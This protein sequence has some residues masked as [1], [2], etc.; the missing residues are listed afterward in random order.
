[1]PV[2]MLAVMKAGGASVALDMS[3]PKT[4][5]RAIL[6]KVQPELILT[7]PAYPNMLSHLSTL[8][9][10]VVSQGLFDS[11]GIHTPPQQLNTAVRPSD[12]LYVVFT[13]GST[14]TPKGVKV[15]HSNFA[16]ALRH[17]QPMYPEA[18]R[19]YDFSSHSFDLLWLNFGSTLST[20]GCLCIP[21]EDERKDDIV[22]SIRRFAATAAL[23]TPTLARTFEPSSVPLLRTVI[24]G[25]EALEKKD[26]DAWSS[27]VDL[28]NAYGPSEC[29]PATT[30][31]SLGRNPEL[32]GAIGPALGM[33]AWIVDSE[34][35]NLQPLGEV[36]E[37][38]LEGPCVGDGYLDDL[39]KT[40]AAF[41]TNPPW[42]QSGSPSTPGRLGRLYR[43]GDMVRYGKDGILFYAGRKDAQVKVRGQRVEL[44]EVEHHVRAVLLG[45]KFPANIV[46]EVLTPTNTK[47]P[48]LI[49]FVAPTVRTTSSIQAH[50]KH[51]NEQLSAL[52]PSYMIPSDYIAVEEI[53][54]LPSGKADRPRLR[55]LG[56]TLATQTLA[57]HE[58]GTDPE[59]PAEKRLQVMWASVLALESSTIKIEDNFLRIGGD[60][61]QAMTLVTHAR[62]QGFTLKVADIF[63]HPSLG[64]QA[65]LLKA[66]TD[67]QGSE[68]VPPFSLLSANQD[69]DEDEMC[70]KVALMTK[71]APA[72]IQD[73]FPCTPLQ[74]GMLA[75][76][77]KRSGDYV[78]KAKYCLSP[79]IDENNFKKAC[80]TL[81]KVTPILRTRIVDLPS[82]GLVQVV[83]DEP[84]QWNDSD[85]A[86][87]SIS[88]GTPLSSFCLVKDGKDNGKTFVWNMHHAIFDGWSIPLML[89]TLEAAYQGREIP[90]ST[91]FQKFVEQIMPRNKSAADAFWRSQLGESVPA[92]FPQL[93]TPTHQPKGNNTL[94]HSINHLSWP[95]SGITPATCLRTAWA[96]LQSCH[97]GSNDIV[98]GATVT[99][100][101]AA[102]P[103]VEEIVGPT[104]ATVPVRAQLDWDQNILQVQDALQK[105]AIDMIPFE[106]IGLQHIR[107]VSDTA[108]EACQ[109]QT[110]LVV[111][112]ESNDTVQSQ[113]FQCNNMGN[114]L[115]NISKTYAL[116]LEFHLKKH[117]VN[118][119]INYDS[120][121]M[122]KNHA[123]RLTGQL[124]HILRQ[125]CSPSAA[126]TRLRD[127]EVTT[128][129]DLTDIWKWNGSLE[130][131]E[132]T[133]VHDLF[134]DVV[135]MNP[136]APAVHAWDGKLTYHQLNE[137]ST[138]LSRQL[139]AIGVGPQTVVPLGFEKSMWTPVSI[140]AVMKA[141]GASL[142][143][144]MTQ[145]EG[146]LL[147]IVEQV[148]PRVVL[149]SRTNS[150]LMQRLSSKV[151]VLVVDQKSLDLRSQDQMY[152]PQS[153]GSGGRAPVTPDDLLYVVFTS[154]STGTPKGVMITH[155]N[156]ASGIKHQRLAMGITAQS[157]TFDFS[158]YLFDISWTTHL[159]TLSAGGCLCIPSEYDRQNRLRESIEEYEATVLNVTPSV[160][161]SLHIDTVPSL[162]RLILSG[163]KVTSNHI[164]SLN[165]ECTTVVTYGTAECTVKATFVEAN[166]DKTPLRT[167]G[168]GRGVN[169]WLVGPNDHSKLAPVGAVGEICIEGPLVGKGYF[170]DPEKTAESFI[171]N[172]TWLSKGALKTS[173]YYPGRRGIVY[174]TGDLA[175]YSEDGLLVY[176]GRKDAQIKIRGQRV[177]LGEVE[178]HV[179]KALPE[180]SSEVVAEVLTPKGSTNSMLVAFIRPALAASDTESE[181]QA[182]AVSMAQGL[183]AKLA[184]VLPPYMI[185]SAYIPMREIP[186]GTTGKLDRR[187][188]RDIG[189]A[190]SIDQINGFAPSQN[191][192]SRR[193]PK[194]GIEE[195]LQ[196][197]WAKILGIDASSIGADDNFFRLG[198]DSIAAMKLVRAAQD[199]GPSKQ[200][201]DQSPIK[202]QDPKSF[203]LF[204][205][206]HTPEEILRI[207][208]PSL[209]ISIDGVQDMYPLP[210]TQSHLVRLATQNPPQGCAFFYI[211]LPSGISQET[212]KKTIASIWKHF[213]IL[214]STH[215]QHEGTTWQIVRKNI[216]APLE[217][218]EI[219]GEE[220]L[221]LFSERKLR[222]DLQRPMKLGEIYSKF[223]IFHGT[224]RPT[225]LAL[226]MSHVQY[227]GLSLQTIAEYI[228]HSINGRRLP[229]MGRY[230]GFVK[231]CM[232]NEE[233]THLYYKSLLQGSK[234]L[235]PMTSAQSTRSEYEKARSMVLYKT[236]SISEPRNID[237]ITPATVFVAASAYV[238]AKQRKTNDVIVS[239]MVSGRSAMPTRMHGLFG[240]LINL[241]P[242][243]VQIKQGETL[244]EILPAVQS[245]RLNSINY[246]AC[247]MS[248]TLKTCVDWP[249]AQRKH[250][251][252][253]QWH[254]LE[255]M[256]TLEGNGTG[257]HL[258]GFGGEDDWKHSDDIFI[259]VEPV[260]G[261]WNV[262]VAGLSKFCTESQLDEVVEGMAGVLQSLR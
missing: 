57:N 61:I 45:H 224:G 140:L 72:Q 35:Q 133:L 222:E 54:L 111:Q 179:H 42:L 193:K 37:L 211:D 118:V 10:M 182:A 185:P 203:S 249:Q 254:T 227:D 152:Q 20:G 229:K 197:L 94:V 29:T 259:R 63:Q 50:T 18:A 232:K 53:P 217:E 117:G 73:V 215:V 36:G 198:G 195:Q 253:L 4:R 156:F 58:R 181:M 19:V 100:R 125:V 123:Q 43:T 242:C 40:A 34:G 33:N 183:D 157:R 28:K 154:G 127:I 101:Q 159:H 82:E 21:S 205:A 112:P 173:P 9:T 99:G 199:V 233:A 114:G 131:P 176:M 202:G 30:C 44:G 3:L 147:S 38:W 121:T 252:T 90:S 216:T 92:V 144:D 245:Q 52:L 46:A 262:Y 128:G 162:K 238:L 120:S 177:E 48:R 241:V 220:N 246:E 104:I 51:V 126:A 184:S 163:E 96:I 14:G 55:E 129:Q 122:G 105:Q 168:K 69:R 32:V 257:P 79:D 210:N 74:E 12:L 8:P 251:V 187:K 110:L 204:S 243:R 15:S 75:M 145:P 77:A 143:L 189:N 130:V 97:T 49:V 200:L 24:L 228:G 149:T 115:D 235:V 219:C 67:G 85:E 148:K 218:Y 261:I 66:N 93:V 135:L 83:V 206:Q 170:A 106:Q 103:G 134:Q 56:A 167:I 236:K 84:A 161:H 256:A 136:M 39:D 17:Q 108:K 119:S 59:T 11:A 214:R 250:G 13:S 153:N 137:L 89:N 98:F 95:R 201:D 23:F 86:F 208:A 87:P 191:S 158:S 258:K 76:T 25:G 260:H 150:S 169:T 102:V 213:E 62:K 255:K 221:A 81:V 209:D 196:E 16:S 107:R 212:L 234:P 47:N 26:Y 80:E 91:P 70:T 1:M 138:Q 172:P 192:A 116:K 165:G 65:K 31:L 5:L 188:L 142:L 244:G 64:E 164:Q 207:T 174:K 223:A 239:L 180:A 71:V 248:D 60:S 178:Y 171:Q 230:S 160:A 166:F 109:F 175:R 226:R 88:L 113:L 141:G 231:Y 146:R 155:S 194:A 247:T 7:S 139:V 41:I 6:E 190:M 132:K 237:G 78:S 2:A 186:M 68:M 27:S 22:A 124:E 225:R 151:L 240:A